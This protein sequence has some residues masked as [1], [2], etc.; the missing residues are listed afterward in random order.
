MGI[1]FEVGE[2]SVWEPPRREKTKRERE[3]SGD[4]EFWTPPVAEVDATMQ[5][6]FRR[7]NVVAFFADPSGWTEMVAKWEARYGARLRV[8]AS[9]REPISAWPRGR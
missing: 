4:A 8:K 1:C 7:Y 3:A 6:A 2:R 9:Q 5:L